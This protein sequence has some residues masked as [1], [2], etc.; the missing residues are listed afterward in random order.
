MHAP[1][2]VCVCVC[3]CVRA[4]VRVCVCACVCVCVCVQIMPRNQTEAQ[5]CGTTIPKQ[6]TFTTDMI[7]FEFHSDSVVT[8]RGFEID[9]KVALSP[10]IGK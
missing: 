2:C 4:R 3:V 8:Y 10:K 9:Y 1:T 5:Y 7:A 6:L